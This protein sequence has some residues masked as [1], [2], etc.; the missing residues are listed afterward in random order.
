MNFIGQDFRDAESASNGKCRY[1]F[2]GVENAG[3]KK[4]KNA[5]KF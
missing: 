5:D 2:A 1:L 3:N 4:C